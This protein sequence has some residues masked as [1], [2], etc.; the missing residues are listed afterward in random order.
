MHQSGPKTETGAFGGPGF[1]LHNQTYRQ[2]RER[3]IFALQPAA[4]NTLAIIWAIAAD[5]KNGDKSCREIT[6]LMAGY[7]AKAGLNAPTNS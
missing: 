4:A 7:V 2:F 5:F 3:S 1:L 6:E